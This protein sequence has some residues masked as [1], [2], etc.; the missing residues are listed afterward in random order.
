M[1]KEKIKYLFTRVILIENNYNNND[2]SNGNNKVI[3]YV[4]FPQIGPHS[5]LQSKEAKHSQ[6]K[7]PPPPPTQ[8]THIP[9]ISY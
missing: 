4:I 8:H 2:S 6:Y 5:S 1:R 7:L 3:F 9:L